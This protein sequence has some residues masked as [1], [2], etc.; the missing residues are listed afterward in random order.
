MRLAFYSGAALILHITNEITEMPDYA[1]VAIL[2][3]LHAE[4]REF[5]REIDALAR[6]DDDE[7]H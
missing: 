2:E 6:N 1:A 5:I 7:F 4:K 3:R